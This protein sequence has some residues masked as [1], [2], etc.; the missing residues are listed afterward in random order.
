MSKVQSK[1]A[2]LYDLNGDA[3]ELKIALREAMELGSAADLDASEFASAGQG[4]KAD[5]AIQPAALAAT[6]TEVI[7]RAN[8]TGEQAMATITGLIAALASKATPADISAA[9]AALVNSSPAALDTLNE[10]A[11]ALG[12]DPNFATTMTTSL[13]N[14]LRVDT[15]AQGLTADQKANGRANLDIKSAALQ[16]ASFFAPALA[17]RG[18]YNLAQASGAGAGDAAADTAAFAAAITGGYGKIII[19]RVGSVWQFNPTTV[20]AAL[21][22]R[23]NGS[24]VYELDIE[25]RGMPEIRASAVGTYLFNILAGSMEVSGL[26]FTDGAGRLQSFMNLNKTTPYRLSV[27]DIEVHTT[28]KGI[29]VEALS[30]AVIS[31]IYG[32][33]VPLLI[34]R[35]AVEST[36]CVDATFENISGDNSKIL[37]QGTG[38]IVTEGV[39]FREIR[40]TTNAGD[41]FTIEQSLACQIVNCMLDGQYSPSETVGAGGMGLVLGSAAGGANVGLS[42]KDTWLGAGK[43]AKAHMYSVPGSNNAAIM[44]DGITC[45]AQDGAVGTIPSRLN[46]TGINGLRVGTVKSTGAAPTTDVFTNSSEMPRDFLPAIPVAISQATGIA[47]ES[48]AITAASGTVNYRKSDGVVYVDGTVTITTAGTGNG[49][50]I[51]SPTG[52][53]A[54]A[55][56][57]AIIPCFLSTGASGRATV[58]SGGSLLLVS[59]SGASVIASGT[60]IKF[61]GCYRA[62]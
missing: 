52:L 16:E 6:V 7:N 15:A 24:S 54:P 49:I 61:N 12:N 27:H 37:F 13:G 26:R 46:L 40:L 22:T 44:I 53:P 50:L 48:G 1:N 38:E 51:L 60:T 55:F 39:T 18:S 25:G 19:P 8:H 23:R 28:A 3:G 36:I 32:I 14:R 9:I 62:A 34:H 57:D 58:S 17:L 43:N 29:R 47:V 35:P 5:T 31:K 41:S 59:S 45:G 30:K 33:D 56:V 21:E 10:L 11:T 42:I 2:F 4:D 20:N